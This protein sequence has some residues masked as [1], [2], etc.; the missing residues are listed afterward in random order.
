PAP[1]VVRLG[2]PAAAASLGGLPASPL[3]SWRSWAPV[4]AA[5]A[6]AAP[7]FALSPPWLR[8][9]RRPLPRPRAG[10]WVR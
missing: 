1:S 6:L 4:R 9:S 3:R 2:P 7:R 5:L 8:G 10:A